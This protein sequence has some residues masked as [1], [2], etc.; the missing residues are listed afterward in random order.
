MDEVTNY[1]YTCIHTKCNKRFPTVKEKLE[2]HWETDQECQVEVNDYLGLLTK[3]IQIYNQLEAP[4]E[5]CNEEKN[6][7][8]E[9]IASTLNSTGIIDEYSKIFDDSVNK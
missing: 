9:K 6:M 2:H 4:E 7:L 3:L 8:K 5:I 1:P